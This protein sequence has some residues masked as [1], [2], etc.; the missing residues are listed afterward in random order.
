MF[1]RVKH[2]YNSFCCPKQPNLTFKFLFCEFRLPTSFHSEAWTVTKIL[3]GLP[4]LI[5]IDTFYVGASVHF[6][7]FIMLIYAV[8]FVLGTGQ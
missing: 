3:S 6:V 4:I 7:A 5:S 1:S 2:D 8:V